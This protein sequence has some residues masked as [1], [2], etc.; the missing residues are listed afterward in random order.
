MK[1]NYIKAV[2][3][4]DSV[5]DGTHDT[6]KPVEK[7]Y[8][9][10]TG[11]HIRDGIIDSGDAYYISERDYEKINERSQ[12]DQWDVLMSMIGNGLGRSAVVK[13]KPDY[14]IKNIALFKTGNEIKAK[15]LHYYLSGPDG[16]GLI[17]GSLQGSGQ[18]FI[19]LSYLRDFPVP[20]PPTDVI[21]KVVAVLERYDDLITNSQRQIKLLD[22]AAHRLYKEWFVDLKFFGWDHCDL[23]DGIPEGWK[24]ETLQ[25]VIGYEIGGGW[26]EDTIKGKNE[27]EAYVIRGTDFA[28]IENGEI[29]SIPLRFHIESNLNARKLLPGDI[30]FEVS[31]GGRDEG[32]ARTILIKKP[33]LDRLNKPVM[34]ASFC[35]L[36]R[37]E[38]PELS[39]YLFEHFRYLRASKITEEFDKRSAS[40]IVNYRWKDFLNQRYILIPSDEVI[41]R[42][43]KIAEEI[44]DKKV[45]LSLQIETLRNARDTMLPKLMSGEIEL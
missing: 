24:Y 27:Y 8:K 44:T 39:Q 25:S 42:Y 4:C 34:C 9:L 15:W 16:Q 3:F 12:V 18:P 37:P 10:V 28:G 26:G 1:W 5:R 41:R 14:A 31:G 19:S 30:V 35:K 43:N 36:V 22:E 29:M 7:G 40:S 32:V 38:R 20:N 11:K 33:L 17:Y 21:E 2:E 6:P 23:S 13:D 45:A